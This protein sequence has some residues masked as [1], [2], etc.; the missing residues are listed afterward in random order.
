MKL[1]DKKAWIESISDT[2]IGTLVNF[3]LNLILLSIT[4]ALEFSVFSTAL[5]TWA[6]FTLV[7]IIRKYLVRRY[8]AKR[9]R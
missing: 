8:F 7:A 3:P 4:F 2:A 6:V 1:G 9:N 5:A